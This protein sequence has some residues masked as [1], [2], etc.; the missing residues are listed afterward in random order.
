MKEKR[1]QA[2]ILM[3]T[4][5]TIDEVEHRKLFGSRLD[6][7][8]L[9]PYCPEKILV[10]VQKGL[11]QR[12]MILKS[13]ELIKQNVFDPCSPKVQESIFNHMFSTESSGRS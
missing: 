8:I 6:D 13:R 1:P 9:K 2:Y 11:R 3:V 10:H 12:E 7:L 4:N 5:T